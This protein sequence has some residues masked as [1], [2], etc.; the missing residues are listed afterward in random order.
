MNTQEILDQAREEML[1]RRSAQTTARAA[2]LQRQEQPWLW[3]FLGLATTL[4]IGIWFLPGNTLADRLH[5]TVQGVCAQA[6][7]LFIG[8]LQMP[9]C[10]RNTG[11]YAGF[12]GTM[13]YLVGLG[14]GRTARLPS[15]AI[16]A[17]LALGV[18]AM[19]VDGTNSL[20]LDM[21][22][23]NLYQPQN[24]LRLVTGLLMGTSMAVFLLLLFNVSLR[25]DAQHDQRILRSW[26][27]YMGALLAD[28]LVFA[29]ISFSPP[30]LFYPLAIFSV[31]GIVGVLFTT[32]IFVVA[33]ISGLENGMRRWGQMA[34]PATIALVLTATEMGLLAWLRM[35]MEQSM[36]MT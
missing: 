36:P 2:R 7:Y 21:G 13:L 33:M 35:W 11:I 31:L 34:R 17:L 29:L 9:L 30:I 25:A 3:A 32:N 4:I 19:A 6:H 8:S 27:E 14:R 15:P 28:A 26:P 22:N 24:V 12:L 10:A 1:R 20:L 5:L 23:H 16:S 18:M